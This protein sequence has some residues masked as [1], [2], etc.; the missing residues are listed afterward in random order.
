MR[1]S[2]TKEY[3]NL[4][5]TYKREINMLSN[6]HSRLG[7]LAL[8]ARVANKNKSKSRD[9]D[10][11]SIPPFL[12]SLGKEMVN[13]ENK[14]RP[15]RIPALTGLELEYLLCVLNFIHHD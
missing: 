1:K 7:N 9:I 5:L 2:A 8:Q 6:T 14:H 3:A 12:F 15:M 10:P 13:C 4:Y 11:A